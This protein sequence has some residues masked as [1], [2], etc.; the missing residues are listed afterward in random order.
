MRFQIPFSS[1]SPLCLLVLLNA[2]I[3]AAEIRLS[4]LA[5]TQIMADEA[6]TP[7]P[8]SKLV[9]WLVDRQGGGNFAE[10]DAAVSFSLPTASTLAVGH[11]FGAYEIIGYQASDGSGLIGS[12]LTIQTVNNPDDPDS[13]ISAGNPV[14]VVWFPTID[15]DPSGSSVIGTTEDGLPFGFLSQAG[16]GGGQWTLPGTTS[17]I[18]FHKTPGMAEFQQFSNQ[19]PSKLLAVESGALDSYAAWT[20][21][22]FPDATDPLLIGAAADPSGSGL[23]NLLRYAFNLS[24]KANPAGRLPHLVSENGLPRFAIPYD[25]GKTDVVWIGEASED[26]LTWPHEI[27]NSTTTTLEPVDGWIEIPTDG[28]SIEGPSLFFRLRVEQR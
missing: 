6:G 21:A 15:Y 2:P 25:P 9:L 26:L 12:D 7:L 22:H 4:G 10:L 27:F 14:G 11:L 5:G 1:L 3:D 20:L 13:T 16:P 23:A 28:L 18:T 24:R 8:A 19:A 17:T